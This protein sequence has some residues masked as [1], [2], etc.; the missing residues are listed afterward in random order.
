MSYVSLKSIVYQRR[1][2][3]GTVDHIAGV[4]RVPVVLFASL[5]IVLGSCEKRDPND[6]VDEGGIVD[7]VYISDEIGWRINIAEGWEMVTRKQ[8]ADLQETGRT[9]LEESSGEE[10]DVS[11]LKNLVSFKKNAFNIFQSTSEPFEEAYPG[12]WSEN[13]SDLRD[14]IL[15]TY[16]DRGMKV[17]ASEIE[18][19]EI[20]GLDFQ[21]HSLQ[22]L[23]PDGDLVLNQVM[24][25]R[26]ING[27]DFGV[28]INYQDPELG[29][30]MLET[31]RNSRFGLQSILSD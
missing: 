13:N 20:D 24:Y 18:T 2:Q 31:W 9:A 21:K 7:G 4:V 12:E 14:L 3:D 28:N 15:Q 29:A 1:V 26:L 23:T 5:L 6:Q 22:I 16:R 19:E 8:T 25:S 27:F 17:N 11:G 10:V 30:E